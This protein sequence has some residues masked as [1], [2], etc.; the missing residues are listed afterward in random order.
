MTGQPAAE[1]STVPL[2]VPILIPVQAIR[3]GWPQ[4]GAWLGL[5]TGQEVFGQGPQYPGKPPRQRAGLPSPPL[6]GCRR[7]M[8]WGWVRVSPWLP[9]TLA[10]TAH[11]THRKRQAWFS[12]CLQDV[13][14]SSKINKLI[15]K[16]CWAR[17]GGRVP[18]PAQPIHLQFSLI[19]ADLCSH[20]HHE[21]VQNKADI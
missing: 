11:V 7:G 17:R 9:V 3:D 13:S 21:H 15:K 6:C 18:V 8:R 14:S 4:C 5:G 20:F 19:W 10:E 1:G 2:P 12:T 16:K